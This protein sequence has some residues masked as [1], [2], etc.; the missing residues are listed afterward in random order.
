MGRLCKVHGH[1]LKTDIGCSFLTVFPSCFNSF[2]WVIT[3]QNSCG[4]EK[5]QTLHEAL[6]DGLR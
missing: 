4:L 2:T 1:G 5:S 6:N 3:S